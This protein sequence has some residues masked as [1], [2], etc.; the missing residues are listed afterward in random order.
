MNRNQLIL[1]IVIGA[2]VG[3]IGYNLS[4]KDQA[5]WS[6]SAQKMGEKLIPDF[7]VNK[8]ESISIKS[9]TNVLTLTRQSDIWVVAERGGYPANFGSIQ[10]FLLKVRD[11]KIA[12]PVKA[13]SGQLAR[14]ELVAPD[15]T[16][17][18]GTLVD[19]KDKSGKSITTLLLGKKH[20]KE[21]PA[22]GQ[23]GGGGWPDGRYVMAGGD[24]KNVA[25]VSEAFQNAE[26]KG[27]EWLDKDFL[28]VEKLRSITVTA[29]QSSNSWAMSRETENGEWK[30]A[31]AK[32][33]EQVDAGKTS[34]LNF[35]LNSPSFHD[36]ATADQ[37]PEDTGLDK[38]L[39]AQLQ[40]FDGFT[41]LVKVGKAN[42]ESR[43][44]LQVGTTA[45]IPKERA[46]G[47]D[48]KPEDKEKLDKE[49][50]EKVQ[51]LQ[52]KLKKEQIHDKWVYL[53][54]KWSID[55]LLKERRE[56]M[57]EKKDEN[58]SGEPKDAPIPSLP[59]GLELPKLN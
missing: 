52:E 4:Q 30:L 50:K 13:G 2:V 39:T 17:N 47:K 45:D 5:T 14:L 28:K 44:F 20:M 15:K 36:V 38:P 46:P 7:D 41:Y 58:K 26:P 55:N 29:L 12:Q 48:E 23:F 31:D 27:E 24:S 9:Q 33:T 21:S 51:K 40:T 37:K 57:A 59:P 16:T 35:L 34:S 3:G 25:L 53:V 1:L 8:V 22:G 18:S 11:V 49:F 54:D 56:F 43:Y 6:Q 32:P 42:A 10:D 19:F